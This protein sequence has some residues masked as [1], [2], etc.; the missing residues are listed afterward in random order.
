MHIRTHL[1]VIA[2]LLFPGCASEQL[3]LAQGTQAGS[4]LED[5]VVTLSRSIARDTHLVS[6]RATSNI[7]LKRLPSVGTSD[8]MSADD[9][10][11]FH[12]TPGNDSQSSVSLIPTQWDADAIQ[13]IPTHWD[14]RAVFAN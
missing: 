6:P 1:L 10:L 14:V 7:A 4:S 3:R 8:A 13:R 12:R 11:A 5:R 9:R 2:I